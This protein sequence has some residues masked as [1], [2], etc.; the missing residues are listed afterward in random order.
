[1][2]QD[3]SSVGRSIASSTL[4]QLGSQIVMA[5]LSIVTTKFVA[6]GLSRDL[7]GEYNT[8]YGYLQ[9]FGILA[10]FGLYAVAVREVSRSANK[11]KT[12]GAL[13]TLRIMILALSMGTALFYVWLNPLW[14]G[15][16]LPLSVTIAAFVPTF[17]LLAGILRTVFQVEYKM[18]FVFMAEVLQRILTVSLTGVF[19]AI[20]FRNTADTRVLFSFLAIGGIGALLLCILS[21]VFSR[22]LMPVR[23]MWDRA[24]L[25]RLLGLC[26]PYGL[27]FFCTA[28]YRQ[29]DVTLIATLRSDYAF[30]NAAYGFVQRMMD[31]AYLIPTF[32]LNSTLP[33]L[34]E[35][36][37]RGED[38]RNL[39]GMVFLAILLLGTTSALFAIFWARPLTELLTTE[40]YLSHPGSP[41]SDTA[42]WILSASMFW[43]GIVL[44]CFYSLLTRHRWKP[45]VSTLALGV[46]VSLVLNMTLIPTYGFV[47]AAITSVITH[48]LLA[49]ILL[50][51][52]LRT[53]PLRLPGRFVVQWILYGGFLALGL[54]ALHPLL[55]NSLRTGMGLL[56]MTGWMA[57]VL[58][59]TGLWRMLKK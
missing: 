7:A 25:Q 53:L 44:F 34:S 32:L 8:A 36:D 45:L 42:L 55:T 58:Y 14:R 17:T 39:V 28:L 24:E 12:M 47:G 50:P 38:T 26:A 40:L 30:Q 13:I 57:L 3:E 46:A 41:G 15:T 31:M 51:Q 20:G 22:K 27:A 37:A 9:L 52:S 48:T 4:W 29:F 2:S 23:P 33:L 43:N 6:M 5:A 18:H 21:I 49:F 35:R 19:I 16:P 56:V 54:Y 59:G 10:D 1:M 11:V